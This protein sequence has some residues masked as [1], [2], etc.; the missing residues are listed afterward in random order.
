M[1]GKKSKLQ[2]LDQASFES[3]EGPS[4]HY[5]LLRQDEP[6]FPLQE[7]K[8]QATRSLYQNL[9]LSLGFGLF[10]GGTFAASYSFFST[11]VLHL[12]W[13]LG[14]IILATRQ[15][16]RTLR[17]LIGIPAPDLRHEGGLLI[18]SI[19]VLGGYLGLASHLFPLGVAGWVAAFLLG[20]PATSMAFEFWMGGRSWLRAGMRTGRQTLRV[21]LGLFGDK[22]LS[23][24]SLTYLVFLPG[25]GFGALTGI[26]LSFPLV[27][28]L[29]PENPSPALSTFLITLISTLSASFF[30]AQ[31]AS[32][33]ALFCTSGFLLSF[34][35]I[36]EEEPQLLRG[37]ES[38]SLPPPN[39]QA[40]LS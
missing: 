28:L 14:A 24:A 18:R 3:H 7:A 2:A 40:L 26:L 30:Q 32:N 17:E 36:F 22:S 21:L 1:P 12:L 16:R 35:E 20:I 6:N 4:Q 39:P 37:E 38:P 25:L 31:L 13:A 23:S 19:L 33:L 10:C 11:P 9:D 5:A 8:R 15:G 34:E 29:P 27:F